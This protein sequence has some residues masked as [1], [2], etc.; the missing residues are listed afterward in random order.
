MVDAAALVA[1]RLAGTPTL[2][3]KEIDELVGKQRAGGVGLWIDLVRV[4]PSGTWERRRADLFG[5][6]EEWIGARNRQRPRP[7]ARRP[8]PAA[9]SRR[10]GR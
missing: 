1:E 10:R 7:G 9:L 8:A 4:P 2:H 5:L 6:A 3:R